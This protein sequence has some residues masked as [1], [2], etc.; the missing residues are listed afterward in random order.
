MLL[1]VNCMEFY[2]HDCGSLPHSLIVQ[3]HLKLPIT[4]RDNLQNATG[5]QG[6]DCYICQPTLCSRNKHLA[7]QI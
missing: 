7:D 3:L 6:N 1:Q 4:V 5:A 2:S